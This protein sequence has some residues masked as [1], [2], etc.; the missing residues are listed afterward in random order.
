M[1]VENLELS[2][3]MLCKLACQE[4]ALIL[5]KQPT[6]VAKQTRP[7]LQS[8]KTIHASEQQ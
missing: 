4:S 2:C 6:D 5:D 1:L 3:Q 8:A 7:I